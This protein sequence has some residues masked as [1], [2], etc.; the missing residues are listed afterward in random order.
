MLMT[1]LGFSAQ[2]HFSKTFKKYV[3]TTPLAFRKA[4]TK[5]RG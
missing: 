2:S 4:R 3:G 1:T 5:E